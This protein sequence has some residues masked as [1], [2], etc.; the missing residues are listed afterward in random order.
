MRALV[1]AAG[2]GTRLRPLTNETPKPL[3]PVLGR[4]MVE[5]VL[6]QLARAGIADAVIN[7]HYL[8]AKM[9]EFVEA[10][11]VRGGVPRLR[12]QDESTEIL[13]SGG[14]VA[15]AAPWLFEQ[16]EAALVCN[17]DVL[18]TPDLQALAA[19]H[20]RLVAGHGVGCTLAVMAH[21]LAGM[22]YTGLRRSGDLVE[23]FE[24]SDRPSRELWHFPGYYVVEKSATARLPEPGKA[25]SVV[26]ALWKPLAAEGK[27]GAWEYRGEYFDLGTVED[28]RSA[29]AELAKNRS[30]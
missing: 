23:A 21:P 5:Y 30:R 7:V 18:G 29:E 24:R 1:M 15:L 9:R 2:L 28:L 13:G 25:F 20:R 3:V 8:P 16:D 14:A 22:K 19:T 12:V 26:D 11:N 6:E 27:L 17:S 10:W 4:P